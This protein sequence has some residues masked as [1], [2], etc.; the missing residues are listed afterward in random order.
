MEMEKTYSQ[1]IAGVFE[2][3]SYILM[4]PAAFGLFYGLLMLLT[5]LK[6]GV[7]A[8]TLL[9]LTPFVLAAV[10]VTLLVGYHKHARGRLAPNR[11]FALWMATA[12][13]N[14]LLA[15]PWLFGFVSVI[16]S[17]VS[18]SRANAGANVVFFTGSVVYV[19]G[20]IIYYALKAYASEKPGKLR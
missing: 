8:E 4:I 1:K 19:Y 16:L 18:R 5:G 7:A 3:L 15:L 14:L 2:V 9:G 20:A 12:V 17:A 10:G 6:R 11:V 13:F